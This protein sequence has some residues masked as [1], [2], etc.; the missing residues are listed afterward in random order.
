MKRA[1]ACRK[2]RNVKQQRR[3]LV[4]DQTSA[5]KERDRNLLAVRSRREEPPRHIVGRIVTR[6]NNL[7]LAENPFAVSKI[8][9]IGFH[10][11]VIDE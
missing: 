10:G 5:I 8:I 11:V 2:R 7:T 9:I 4:Q 3:G 6:G 1:H